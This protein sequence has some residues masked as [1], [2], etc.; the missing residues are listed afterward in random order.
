MDIN[1]SQAEAE[2]LIAMHKHRI[3]DDR[4]DYP[5]VGGALRIPLAS[6]DRREDFML[7]ITRGRIELTKCTFQN[8]ARHI[9]GLIRVDVGGSIHRNPDNAWI[10]CPHIHIYREGFGVKWAFPLPPDRFTNP[11]NQWLTLQEFMR[12]CNIVN[13]PNI[14]GRLII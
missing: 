14:T 5:Y 3:N 9:I 11:D 7:D 4:H 2:A 10:P 13:P 8:R 1:L 12:Y 6:E